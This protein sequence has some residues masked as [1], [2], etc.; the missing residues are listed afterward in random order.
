MRAGQ[1]IGAMIAKDAA[2]NGAGNISTREACHSPQYYRRARLAGMRAP[3]ITPCHRTQK[4]HIFS[5]VDARDDASAAKSLYL[6]LMMLMST[7]GF[8]N[9][10]SASHLAFSFTMILLAE[11]V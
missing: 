11:R 10:F 9:A 7:S 2:C 8:D 6:T 5:A 3:A 1:A 4:A